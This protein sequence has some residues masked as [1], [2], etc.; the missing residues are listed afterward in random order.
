M[1]EETSAVAMTGTAFLYFI[2]GVC[3]RQSRLGSAGMQAGLSG[4]SGGHQ[5]FCAVQLSLERRRAEDSLALPADQRLGRAC[6]W[7]FADVVL[8]ESNRGNWS[9]KEQICC[10]RQKS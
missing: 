7:G 1:V 8:H 4:K 3:E 10:E 2:V 6:L 5:M 9:R